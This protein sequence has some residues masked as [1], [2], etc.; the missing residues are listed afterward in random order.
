MS[1]LVA[2]RARLLC[3]EDIGNLKRAIDAGMSSVSQCATGTMLLDGREVQV[4]ER[5]TPISTS[6]ALRLR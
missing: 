6:P 1:G 3:T 2:I 5:L 4:E